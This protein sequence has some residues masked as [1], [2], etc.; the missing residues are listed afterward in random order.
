LEA[1]KTYRFQTVTTSNS[2]GLVL[3][4]PVY[5]QA[6]EVVTESAGPSVQNDSIKQKIFDE[7]GNPADGALVLVSVEGGDYPVSAWVDSSL[8]DPWAQADLSQ[9]YSKNTHQP[10]TL[11]G[12]EEVTLWSFGGN[13]GNY[14]NIQKIGAPTGAAQTAL[15]EDVYLD[16]KLGYYRDLEID[17]NITGLAVYANPGFRR[18]NRG[19]GS[20]ET[21]SWFLGQP[22]GVDFDIEPG[23]AYL[24]YMA[25]DITNIWFE[26]FAL[27]AAVD[28][29]PGLN[30]S[31]VPA[32][33]QS[34]TYDSYEMLTG[35]GAELYL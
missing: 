10:L 29:S 17:L 5:F 3:V 1:G 9:L 16:T 33:K 2:T 30:L 20:W 28:L 15:P 18:Y 34:F 12:D 13:L 19:T 25:R 8:S 7:L 4:N 11:S 22:A 32:A 31:C 14:V 23:E 24:I 6:L 26:G 21:A 35:L 27:G